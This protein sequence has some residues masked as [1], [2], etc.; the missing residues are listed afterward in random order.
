MR[1]VISLLLHHSLD[2]LNVRNID[3]G[4]AYG[5]NQTMNIVLIVSNGHP[6]NFRVKGWGLLPHT[7][8]LSYPHHDA[9]GTLTRTR[10]EFG[11]TFWVVFRLKDKH[12]NCI[13]LQTFVTNLVDFPSHM[14]WVRKNCVAEVIILCAGDVL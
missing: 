11:V 5:W 10:T 2:Q 14:A 7:E 12:D 8:F 9:E 3:H 4:L 13:H 1:L 6:D